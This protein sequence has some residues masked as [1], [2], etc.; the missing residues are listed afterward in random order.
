MMITARSVFGALKNWLFLGDIVSS[1]ETGY[2]NAG[3]HQ[4]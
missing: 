4:S 3:K 1:G 2:E